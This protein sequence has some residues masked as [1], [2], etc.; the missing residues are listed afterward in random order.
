[1][2]LVEVKSGSDS[3]YYVTRDSKKNIDKVFIEILDSAS[4]KRGLFLELPT[5]DLE[6]KRNIANSTILNSPIEE[7]ISKYNYDQLVKIKLTNLGL[8]GWSLSGDINKIISQTSYSE[9]IYKTLN[10]FIDLMIN[11]LSQL[12]KIFTVSEFKDINKISRKYAIPYLEYL[13]QNRL[14]KKIDNDGKR[15]NLIS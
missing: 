13:D 4:T 3:S 1:M 8:D 2:F 11:N 6:D 14:T 9:E 10:D 5:F 12:P 7:I 15:E